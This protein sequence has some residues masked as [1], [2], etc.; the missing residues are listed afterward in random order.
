MLNIAA[1]M[2][3]LTADPEMKTTPSG[4]SVTTFTLAVDRNYAEQGEDGQADFIDVVAWRGTADFV[5]RYFAK[6]K[7]MAVNGRIQTRVYEDKHGN[8]RKAVEIVA[9]QISFCGDWKKQETPAA[10]PAFKEPDIEPDIEP[11][12]ED[13]QEVLG[14][15]LPFWGD[16]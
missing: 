8:K 11:D 3:W 13:F 1:I 14:D 6:G 12:E 7:M 5:C 15:D 9:D 4:V 10:R 16:P 2:G